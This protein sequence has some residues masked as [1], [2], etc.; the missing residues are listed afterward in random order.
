MILRFKMTIQA[1]ICETSFDISSFYIENSISGGRREA[2]KQTRTAR[3][4]RRP[5]QIAGSLD[6][7]SEGGD[8]SP[9][10]ARLASLDQLVAVV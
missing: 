4:E 10:L 8:R 9:R 1:G 5:D 2:R 6:L 3:T 7:E